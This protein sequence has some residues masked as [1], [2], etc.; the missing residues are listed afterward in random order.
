MRLGVFSVAGEALHFGARRMETIMR[1]AWLPVSLLLIVNMAAA[2]SYLSVSAGRLITFSDLAS[3][4]TFAMVEAYAG[5]AA[6]AGLGAGSAGVWAIALA[7]AVINAILI[8]SF[9]APLIR[10]AGLGEKPAPGVLRMPFGPDQLRF[11][12]AGIVSFLISALLIYAPIAMATYF[13]ISAITRALTMAYASFPDESSL[14][15]VEIVQGAEVLAQRGALWMYEY[16]YWGVAATALVA[17]LIVTM[18]AH[19]R[20]RRDGQAALGRGLTVFAAIAAFVGAFAFA[21]VVSAPEGAS[22]R[23]VA[24]LSAFAAAALAL[25]AYANLRLYPYTAIAVCRR[26]FAPTGLLAVTRGGNIFRLFLIVVMLGLLL[27]LA[28]ILLSVFGIDW[29]IVMF[30]ALGAAVASYTGLFNGGEAATWVAPL[31]AAL[32]AGVQIAF[33]MFWL[34]YTYGVS[35]GLFGR[36]YRESEAL[37]G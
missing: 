7:S 26:S 33:T 19:F 31:F 4:Q 11:I 37:S 24:V 36:L 28:E 12:L 2:F 32:V 17:V 23:G 30:S 3:G 18:L 1:V 21:G 25:A 13:I 8:A 29:I 9:M 35:A 22:P 10:Y 6:S 5:Q 15:T 27:F 34:F 16:G 14:H 20:R